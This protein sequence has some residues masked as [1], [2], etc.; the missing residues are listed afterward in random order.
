MKVQRRTF[1]TAGPVVPEENYF[2][3]RERELNDFLQRVERGKYIVIS[4]PRQTGK[5]TFFY[6]ALNELEKDSDY[7][8][9]ALNFEMYSELDDETFYQDIGERIISR[10]K[11]RLRAIGVLEENSLNDWFETQEIFS[12]LTFDKFFRGFHHRFPKKVFL[13]IDEFDGIPQ[14]ALKGF[15]HTLRQIYL[16]KRLNSD[17]NYIHSVGIVGVKSIAQLNFDHSISPFN[18]QDQFSLPNFTVEQIAELYGQYTDE[19]GQPFARE[20]V[21]T[22]H[23]K[24]A[25]QPFLVNRLAQILTKELRISRDE[26]ITLEH[27]YKAHARIIKEDNIHFQHLRRNIRRKE[28]FKKI[29]NRILFDEREIYFNINDD[30]INELTTYGLVKENEEGVC[31]IDN[32]IYQKI[33][34]KTFTPAINGVEDEYLTE[35][36]GDFTSYLSENDEIRMGVLLDNFRDFIER[37]GYKILLVP[38]TPQEFVGQYL[39]LAYL[40]LFVRKIGAHL[41]PEV[42]TGRGRMDIIILYHAQKYI[43]ETKLWRGEKRYQSGKRQ[44]AAY[45]DKERVQRGY[46]I[47]FDRSKEA[48]QRYEHEVI[49]GKEIISYCIP[50]PAES[51]TNVIHHPS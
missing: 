3:K 38:E 8:P 18:I 45:L 46:Y 11:A 16:E 7:I 24:T 23:Q 19:T 49:N 48:E 32:S 51:V 41:Y 1:T 37:A 36:T 20:V 43:V 39:L 13:V 9:I 26:E 50:I 47:V 29:L 35:E 22:V 21:E 15:L 17:H 12:F 14:K 10:I 2:V 31:I 44:L 6:D 25:G 33:I 28:E 4:A 42:P 40:D 5:T 34:V 27:F 30:S